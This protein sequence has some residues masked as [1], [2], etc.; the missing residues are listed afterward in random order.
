MFRTDW[1]YFAAERRQDSADSGLWWHC[2]KEVAMAQDNNS[3]KFYGMFQQM[4][5][6]YIIY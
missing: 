5:I 3:D 6:K 2:R 1:K 4:Y